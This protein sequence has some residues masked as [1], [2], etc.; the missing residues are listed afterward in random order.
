MLDM[1]N[2]AEQ[3]KCL[4]IHT[5]LK[6]LKQPYW[7]SGKDLPQEQ[8][9]WIRFPLLPWI[10]L[11]IESDLSTDTS[12]ATLPGT[13]HYRVS[14]GTSWPSVSVRWLG[15]AARLICIFYHSVAAH[16]LVWADPSLRDNS[17]LQGLLN[18]QQTMTTVTSVVCV[19]VAE[20]T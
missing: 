19:D 3:C 13:W 11:E 18:N 12:V 2:C 20:W 14:A 9:T 7:P 15:E 16:T 17:M 6:N 10:F 8:Q 1:L 5:M 4:N